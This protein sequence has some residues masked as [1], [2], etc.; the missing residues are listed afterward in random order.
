MLGNFAVSDAEYINCGGGIGLTWIG[1]IRQPLHKHQRDIR[2][3]RNDVHQRQA[4]LRLHRAW[5][6]ELG[7][8][9]DK[10]SAAV[11][12]IWIVLNVAFCQIRRGFIKLAGVYDFA[13]EIKHQ[14]FIRRQLRIWAL[15]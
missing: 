10:C 6:A 13:P 8:I 1:F 9:R 11:G 12:D 5:L 3:F 15:Q 4:D 7:K 14:L 2:A